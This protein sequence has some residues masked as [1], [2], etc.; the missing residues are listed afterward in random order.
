M[1]A[2]NQIHIHHT[3][4]PEAVDFIGTNHDR[5]W[6]NIRRY[7][8]DVRG[9]MDIGYN[10]GVFP[11]GKIL[12]GRKIEIKPASIA[13]HNTGAVAIVMIGNFDIEIP[14]EAQMKACL[15]KTYSLMQEYSVPLERVFFHNEFDP[16]TC[17][18]KNVPK[19]QFIS[20]LIM[21]ETLDEEK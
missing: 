12:D 13:N 7:H 5:I 17:P 3:Y 2:I 6:E 8:M 1:R 15:E 14:S 19:P 11:D 4:K 10:F 21:M 16:K 9:W 18:G 20:D